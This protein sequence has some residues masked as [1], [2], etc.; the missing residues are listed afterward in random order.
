MSF[1]YSYSLNQ[2][3]LSRSTHIRIQPMSIE[4]H[5]SV[6][7]INF[8]YSYRD[9]TNKIYVLTLGFNQSASSTHIW[10]CPCSIRSTSGYPA[11]CSTYSLYESEAQHTGVHT[12]PS[13]HYT[14]STAHSNLQ[15]RVS[16]L[17]ALHEYIQYRCLYPAF[18]TLHS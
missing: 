6:Q 18:Y 14:H 8:G 1:E 11:S 2:L 16:H 10:A 3:A 9:S 12:L 7:P 15:Y 17:H 5:M 4:Y 13:T